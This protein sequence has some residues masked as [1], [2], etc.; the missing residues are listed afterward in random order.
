MPPAL[1]LHLVM[2]SKY[3]KFEVLTLFVKWAKFMFL[4][5]DNLASTI[6]HFFFKT[7]KL[8]KC[9]NFKMNCLNFRVSFTVVEQNVV[10]L[11]MC[12]VKLVKIRPPKRETG[13]WS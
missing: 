13:F 10:I 7:N 1:K 8:K 9:Q 4:H 2:M 11:S 6:T 5:N 12:T 3:S